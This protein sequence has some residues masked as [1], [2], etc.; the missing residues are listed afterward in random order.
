MLGFLEKITLSPDEVNA[1][2]AAILLKNGISKKAVA[3]AL[4]V[5]VGFNIINRLADAF[6]ANVP[7]PGRFSRSARFL[8]RFG[9][10]ILSGLG[11]EEFR[12]QFQKYKKPAHLKNKN[13]LENGVENFDRYE[14]M[15]KKLNRTIFEENGFLEPALRKAAGAAGDLPGET[16]VYVKKVYDNAYRITDQDFF[17][18]RKSGFS[19]EQIFEITVCAAL[20]AGGIRLKAGLGNLHG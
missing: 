4:Y 6:D 1:G 2:D 8:L 14:E 3:D 19:E 11:F 10:Q 16:G 12:T 9:Y 15:W 7:A 17:D 5:C 13:E 20:G 18:L